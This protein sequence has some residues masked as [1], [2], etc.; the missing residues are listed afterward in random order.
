MQAAGFVIER[1]I[2]WGFPFYSPLYRWILTRTG[3]QGTDGSY[4]LKRKVLAQVLYGTFLLNSA[5]R[6]DLIFVLA[7]HV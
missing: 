3:G 4:G 2:E 6:G 1:V 5:N 7:S